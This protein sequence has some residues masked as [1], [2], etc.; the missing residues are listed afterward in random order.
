MLKV[1]PVFGRRTF[2]HWDAIEIMLFVTGPPQITPE[3]ATRTRRSQLP[4]CA[5]YGANRRQTLR[6]A[7]LRRAPLAVRAQTLPRLRP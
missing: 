3:R 1:D 5:N 6:A 4:A 2:F 7:A